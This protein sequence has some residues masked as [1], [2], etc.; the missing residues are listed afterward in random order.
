MVVIRSLE[1][2]SQLFSDQSPVS[3][4]SLVMNASVS[5]LP[6]LFSSLYNTGNCPPA[7]VSFP[8][9]SPSVLSRMSL[10]YIL[11]II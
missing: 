4:I 5:P 11:T 7:V 3:S 6:N 10:G 2:E 9:N 8:S 1:P